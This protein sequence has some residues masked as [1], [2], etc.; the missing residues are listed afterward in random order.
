ML[1]PS[2]LFGLAFA[3]HESGVSHCAIIIDAG[4]SGTRFKLYHW[5]NSEEAWIHKLPLII[6]E[7]YNAEQAPLVDVEPGIDQWHSQ[8]AEMIEDF[9]MALAV[10]K[11]HTMAVRHPK[12]DTSCGLTR[13]WLYATAGLR[14]GTASQARAI[15]DPVEEWF[16]ENS[17]FEWMGAHILSGTE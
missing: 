12:T 17:P 4:S 11:E 1:L 16:A 6:E 7:K 5:E 15:L 13:M 10:L 14:T 8:S 9:S 2:L 3:N